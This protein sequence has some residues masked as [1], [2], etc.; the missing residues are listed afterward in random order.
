MK[1]LNYEIKKYIASALTDLHFKDFSVV[2]KEVFSN[3]NKGKNLLVKSKTGSG[4]THAFLVPIFNNLDEDLAEVQAVIVSPTA[5][6]ANQTYKV[7]QHIASFSGKEIKV[8]VYNGGKDRL[9]EIEEL[10]SG[11]PQIVIATPGKLKDLAVDENV[12][13]IYTAK[14]YVIDE[15]DMVMDEGFGDDIDAI[16]AILPNAF[17]M[18]F[19]ATLAEKI[20]PFLKKYLEHP[21]FIE[22]KDD[23]QLNI[24][25]IWIPL[26]YKE[27]IDVLDSLLEVI[28]PYIC[29]IFCNKK[30]DVIEICK[31]L[32]DL[33]KEV[34]MIQGDLSVRERKH[35]LKEANELKYQYIVASDIASRGIDIDGVSHIINYDLPR[36]FEFYLHR[37]GRTGRM[38]Y[39]GVVYSFYKDLDNE[40]LDYLSKQGIVPVYKEI[41]GGEIVDFKGR[42][43]RKQRVKPL[44]EIEISARKHIAKPKKVTPGY[45]KKMKKEADALATRFYKTKNYK[46]HYEAVRQRKESKGK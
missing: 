12:L 16:T 35:I 13:K 39:S 7:A 1:F 8:K 38:N 30:N 40:Y 45:K 23:S 25:H 37:A 46:E 33:G 28:N 2:Q 44:N 18:F 41:K 31:H 32:K 9:R 36:D 6:L 4:K 34:A 24:E 21:I 5:E 20:Q 15:V 17:K 3:L 42:N 27:K 11:Q 22:I 14:Y 26:K 19:S 43:T 10:N 29:I